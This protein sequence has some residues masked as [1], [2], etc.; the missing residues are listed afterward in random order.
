[1]CLLSNGKNI[2]ARLNSIWQEIAVA[3]GL[4]REFVYRFEKLVLTLDAIADKLFVKTVKAHQILSECEHLT[5]QFR[6]ER[7][8]H[9]YRSLVL[10]TRLE[11]LIDGLIKETYEF[12]IKA[13]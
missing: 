1:M 6:S 11:G 13:G 10:L 3:K 9:H 5:E 2:I 7:G 12:R 8:K 4:A